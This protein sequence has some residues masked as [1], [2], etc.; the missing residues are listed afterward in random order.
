MDGFASTEMCQAGRQ[1][2]LMLSDVE[3]N[4]ISEKL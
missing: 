4:R 3:H 2:G 1:A